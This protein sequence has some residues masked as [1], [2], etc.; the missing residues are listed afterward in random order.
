MHG[1]L[2]SQMM[3]IKN[4]INCHFK[5]GGELCIRLNYIKLLLCNDFVI[6]CFNIRKYQFHAVQPN[7]EALKTFA[8]SL[9]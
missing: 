8:I 6:D 3:V 2:F 1:P 9:L 5:V 4:R 7:T